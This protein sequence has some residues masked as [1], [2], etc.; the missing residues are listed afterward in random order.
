MHPEYLSREAKGL[1]NNPNYK[2]L[3]LF[4][5]NLLVSHGNIIVRLDTIKRF[6]FLIVYP[7]ASPFALPL[8]FPLKRELIEKEV[9]A[10]S[11]LSQQEVRT[12]IADYIRWF[13][14]YRHQ[15]ASGSLCILEW[16]N[17]DDGEKFYGIT[18]LLNRVK[19]W[20]RGTLT[21]EFPPDSQEVEFTS[22]FNKVD[23]E[24]HFL[25]PENFLQ[26]HLVRGIAYG[27]LYS[28]NH[29][30]Q[31]HTQHYNYIGTLLT[32]TSAAGI[33]MPSSGI[34]PS[35]FTDVGILNELKIIELSDVVNRLIDEKRLLK[36]FWFQ[37]EKEPAP[38][39]S[40]K[41]LSQIIGDGNLEVGRSRLIKICFEEIKV[42]P[43]QFFVA[44]RF[45]NRRQIQEFQ[46]LKITKTGQNQG[47]LIGQSDE[48]IFDFLLDAYEGIVAVP[49]V[50]FSD[51]DFH[52]RNKGRANRNIL[53]Q[54][55]INLFGVG[56][57]GSETGDCL[58]KAG[59][60]IL[61]LFDNQLLKIEN[62][63]RHLVG[64]DNS[65][66]FK[67][68]AVKQILTSHNPFIQVNAF[69]IDVFGLDFHE[70][71]MEGAIGISSIAD[72][73]VEAYLNERA[74][75][76]DKPVYYV[77]ALRGGKMARIFRVIPGKDACFHCLELYRQQ[78]E[79]FISIPQDP[80]LPTLRNE[81]NNPIRPGSAAD[82]KLISSLASRIIIDDLEKGFGEANHWIWSTEKLDSLLPFQLHQQTIP[83]HPNCLYCNSY[84]KLCVSVSCKVME[85]MKTL[86]AQDPKIETG[87]VLAG[88]FDEEGSLYITHASGPGPN[89]IL[90]AMRFEKDVAFCQ[91]FLDDLTME[92]GSKIHYIGEWHSHPSQNNMP[93]FTDLKSLI[94]IA[95][96]NEYLTEKPVMI[97]LSNTGNPSCTIH[98]A[99]KRYYF[100][101]LL[102]KS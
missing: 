89:A 101:E 64:Y 11:L 7:E 21:G 50:L 23:E 86:V 73:N 51:K 41:Q 29:G 38:F 87:G 70:A 58:A 65:G 8:F 27:S 54:K 52:L 6:P 61:N 69:N 57:L 20:C 49:S 78:N 75:L 97:I 98:P 96:Q 34:F 30:V 102:I 39:L 26:P 43:D 59:I 60:G 32:G 28:N 37:I 18:T 17:L 83:I 45:P 25:Y 55:V 76:A 88:H 42:K 33:Q 90:S 2:Q 93:S 95:N 44:L 99:G 46:V 56:A 91:K 4:R 31:S 35:I 67:A 100:G 92:S 22:H 74:V 13:Y 71:I 94:Q 77:R 63:V 19:N 3:F 5:N 10:I 14:E 24:L 62:S 9:K 84:Q 79:I 68:I 36:I 82:L 47:V 12:H 85:F 80:N 16:D 40:F 48:A 66:I 1:S 81:C 15:N 53:S 72:D